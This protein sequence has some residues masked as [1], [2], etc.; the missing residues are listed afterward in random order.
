[1]SILGFAV[2]SCQRK[3]SIFLRSHF[4]SGVRVEAPL[5]NGTNIHQNEI[6]CIFYLDEHTIPVAV[7]KKN[8]EMIPGCSPAIYSFFMSEVSQ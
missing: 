2:L 7:S 1:M 4:E 5:L 3:R 6:R 8:E